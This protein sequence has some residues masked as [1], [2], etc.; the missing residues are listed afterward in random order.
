MSKQS[1]QIKYAD[2]RPWVKTA[3]AQ[4]DAKPPT[5]MWTG[6]PSE[7]KINKEHQKRIR[8]LRKH[9]KTDPRA[10]SL[11]ERLQFCRLRRRCLSGACLLCGR[12]VQRWFVRRSKKF[13]ARH[14]ET[15]DGELVAI[16]IVP[17]NPIILPPGRLRSLSIA[18]FQRRVKY[19]L[20]KANIGVAIG[21]VDFSFN[22]DRKGTYQSF[23]APH[24]YVITTTRNK[25]AVKK[26][27]AKWFPK[28]VM[29][30][31]PI[32][33]PSF[34]NKAYRRSYAFK[35]QF[36]RRIGYTQTKWVKDQVRKCRNTSRDKLRAR[37]RLEFL[38]FSGSSGPWFQAGLSRG[39]ATR[40]F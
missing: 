38:L 35:T 19:A 39:E 4:E 5:P 40:Q 6:K 10:N 26:D 36:F 1:P 15:Q 18:N 21:G 20:A 17:A 13:I 25:G 23:W 16:I 12:L 7:E 9:G 8:F 31:R 2:I 37:E 30:P 33:T 32:K 11:A 3:V 22:E 27:L 29:I 24:L 14:L 28:S 34:E